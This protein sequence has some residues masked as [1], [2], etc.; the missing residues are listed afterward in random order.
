MYNESLFEKFNK[1]HRLHPVSIIVDYTKIIKETIFGFGIGLIITLKESFFYFILFAVL[2]LLVLLIYSVLSWLRFT[3]Y[4]KGDELRIEQGVFIRKK[5]YISKHRIHKI[6]I[7]A[8]VVHRI[9]RLVKLQIDTASN[10]G[11]AEVYLS[12]IS[13]SDAEQLRTILQKE[14]M[15]SE[16]N[17]KEMA[18]IEQKVSWRRL[19]IAGSTS[20]SAGFI[21]L[22]VLTIF[23]QIE[24]LIPRN[25][26]NQAYEWFVSLGYLFFILLF[27]LILFLLWLLGIAGTM[28]RYGNFVIQKRKNE[29]FIRRGLLETKELTIP[30]ERIQAVGIEQSLIRQPFRFVRVFAVVAGGSFDKLEAFPILFPIMRQKE[31][32]SFIEAFL[33]EYA[34][35]VNEDLSRIPKRSLKYYIGKALPL[36]ILAAIPLIIFNVKLLWIPFFLFIAHG[37]WGYAQYRDAGY[38]MNNHY[39]MMQL[40][41]IQKVRILTHKK[42]IQSLEK[43]QHKLQAY[44]KL[45][46]L[47]ISLIGDFGLGTHYSL[48]HLDNEDANRIADWYSY[49]EEAMEESFSTIVHKEQGKI[50][51]PLEDTT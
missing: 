6:D 23:S 42:R 20:G 17:E 50:D 39:L 49:R 33:P 38:F 8:N 45:A 26:F 43:K 44:D 36:P 51:D 7:T 40:R 4:V 30:Y 2:F 11:G 32:Q 27:I 19:F 16:E 3:Y 37:L 18:V 9:F 14:K 24:E 34:P 5:R 21:I 47:S 13:V 15:V 29:L 35:Y 1:P 22:A 12:A 25:A 28:V 46:S 41:R 48:R 10:S 31:V